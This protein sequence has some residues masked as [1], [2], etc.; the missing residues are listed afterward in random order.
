MM[1]LVKKTKVAKFPHVTGSV[2]G[3]LRRAMK[4]AMEQ[5][6]SRVIIVGESRHR[7]SYQCSNVIDTTA[8]G[9]LM[10]AIIVIEI[11]GCHLPKDEPVDDGA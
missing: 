10:K 9:M 8:M 1:K 11:E 3:T 2:K 4:K 7:G 6:W 5:N